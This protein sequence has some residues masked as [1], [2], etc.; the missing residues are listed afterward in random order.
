M[1]IESSYFKVE[2]SKDFLSGLTELSE[3]EPSLF[4]DKVITAQMLTSVLGAHDI[5]NLVARLAHSL[6][7]NPEVQKQARIE[8]Q[9]AI[10]KHVRT[11]HQSRR[12]HS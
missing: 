1:L 6:A 4:N 3:E 10:I 8:I 5:G 2:R 7:V 12:R 11:V 9:E